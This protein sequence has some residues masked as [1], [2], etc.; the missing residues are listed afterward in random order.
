MT[1]VAITFISACLG[2]VCAAAVLCGA[3]VIAS[4]GVV[5]GALAQ[6]QD[7]I[8]RRYRIAPD[9]LGV[10]FGLVASSTVRLVTVLAGA[11]W[12]FAGLTALYSLLTVYQMIR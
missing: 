10:P 4:S 11:G 1:L 5:A 6:L 3:G 2:I 9:A 7:R 8:Y 12:I